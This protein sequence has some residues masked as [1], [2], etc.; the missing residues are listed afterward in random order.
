MQGTGLDDEIWRMIW[1]VNNLPKVKKS[2]WH[3]LSNVVAVQKNLRKRGM[4]VEEGCSICGTEETREHMIY[5]CGW[6]IAM[7]FDVLGRF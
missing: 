7:W 5:G 4:P 6:T 3:L 1:K 2:M